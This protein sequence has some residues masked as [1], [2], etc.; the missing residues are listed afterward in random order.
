MPLNVQVIG[1]PYTEE[2]VLRAMAEVEKGVGDFGLKF[3]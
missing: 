1:R 3:E 2:L